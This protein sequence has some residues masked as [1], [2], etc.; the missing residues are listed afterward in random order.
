MLDIDSV[1]SLIL[2]LAVKTDEELGRDGFWTLRDLQG[3][4]WL[5]TTS[6]QFIRALEVLKID[7]GPGN[8]HQD[9]MQLSVQILWCF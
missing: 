1:D 7:W 6:Y 3:T 2:N 9:F 5:G 8:I 4:Y